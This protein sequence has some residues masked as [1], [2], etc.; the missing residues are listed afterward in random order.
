L[1]G[2]G[3]ADMNEI[4]ARNA[5]AA[6]LRP[7]TGGDATPAKLVCTALALALIVLVLRIATVW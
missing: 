7:E 6:R 4:P 2:P 1:A 5:A 3:V